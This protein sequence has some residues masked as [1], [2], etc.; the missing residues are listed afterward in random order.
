MQALALGRHVDAVIEGLELV[1]LGHFHFDFVSILNACWLGGLHCLELG[2]FV[3]RARLLLQG[4][5][6]EWPFVCPV[7]LNVGSTPLERNSDL[8]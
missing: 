2:F 8:A 6:V 1:H 3:S 5:E 4:C 7:N